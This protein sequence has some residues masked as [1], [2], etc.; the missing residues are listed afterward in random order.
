[1]PSEKSSKKTSEVRA[2]GDSTVGD[3]SSPRAVNRTSRNHADPGWFFQFSS[4]SFPCR[5]HWS[6]VRMSS[7]MVSHSEFEK[8]RVTRNSSAPVK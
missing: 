4:V 7:S 8:E 2:G 6:F 1:M 5:S 3:H